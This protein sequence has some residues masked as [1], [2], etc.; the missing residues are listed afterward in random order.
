[1]L[2][3]L[4][5]YPEARAHWIVFSATG[6][7]EREARASEVTVH[8]VRD[9]FFPAEYGCLKELSENLKR[10]VNPDIIL[11]HHRNDAH[12]DHRTVAELSS[13]TFHNHLMLEYEIPKYDP[14]LSYTPR[15]MP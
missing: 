5:Q 8:V 6:E 7:Q 15:R 3:R 4:G 13:A 2:S 11:T 14:D 12:Q 1:M 9:G 10:T